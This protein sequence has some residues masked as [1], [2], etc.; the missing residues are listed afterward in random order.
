MKK[1]PVVFVALGVSFDK[2]ATTFSISAGPV[3]ALSK[4]RI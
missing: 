2:N 1:A 4:P 3:Y